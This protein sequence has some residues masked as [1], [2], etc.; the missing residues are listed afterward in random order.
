MEK[1]GNPAWL[2]A[3]PFAWVP[4]RVLVHGE[5]EE[6]GVLSMGTGVNE[7]HWD[8]WDNA[9][10]AKTDTDPHQDYEEF[11][12][13]SDDIGEESQLD[14]TVPPEVV[15]SAPV[16][17]ILLAKEHPVKGNK[18]GLD[19]PR[20][21]VRPNAKDKEAGETVNPVV[22]NA[23]KNTTAKEPVEDNVSDDD[24]G[25]DVPVAGAP[26]VPIDEPASNVSENVVWV[27]AGSSVPQVAGAVEELDDEEDEEDAIEDIDSTPSRKK[28]NGS[29][30]GESGGKKKPLGGIRLTIRDKQI[31]EFLGRYR[32]ATV[33]QLSRRFEVGEKTLRNR[34]P[35]LREAGL[36]DS[37]FVVHARPQV[38]LVTAT[39]LTTIGMNLTSPSIRWGQV[40]HTMW[41]ADLGIAFEVAGENVLTERE[42]RAAATRYS[43][44]V[45]MQAS[46]DFYKTMEMLEDFEDEESGMD[47]RVLTALTVPVPGRGIGHIPDMVLARQPFPNGYSGSIAIELE[48]TRK[49]LGEWKTILTAF[50]DS[51]RFHEVYYYVTST[52]VQR[53]VK[54]VVKAINA[55]DKI[56]VVKFEPVDE[57]ARMFTGTE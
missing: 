9:P 14:N 33:S 35:K 1:S 25:A 11:D 46:V 57:T 51:D 22:K 42:I 15:N 36:V 31:M 37:V 53:A 26:V 13:L 24:W 39:G 34:L 27:E 29:R 41:L 21:P 28:K 56:H 12:L 10:E 43:P 2:C 40:R 8:D 18:V 23:S 47:S 7:P 3:H 32:Y 30:K 48:L 50:R 17:P 6:T 54:R 16:R 45:R 44:T 52:E 4:I 19:N 49:N 20:K 5:R 38:W 55:E